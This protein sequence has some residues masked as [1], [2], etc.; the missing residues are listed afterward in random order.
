M[1][2]KQKQN[3]TFM[4]KM[5]SFLPLQIKQKTQT[6]HPSKLKE[7]KLHAWRLANLM[8]TLRHSIS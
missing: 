6:Q 8:P 2:L 3:L 4:V 7:E 5:S 1:S